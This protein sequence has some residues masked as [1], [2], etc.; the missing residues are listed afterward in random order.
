M[1]SL[2]SKIKDWKSPTPKVEWKSNHTNSLLQ[3]ELRHE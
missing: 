3:K 2:V 1:K